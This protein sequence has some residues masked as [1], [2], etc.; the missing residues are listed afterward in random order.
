M[1]TSR[2]S[3]TAELW[4]PLPCLSSKAVTIS[5]WWVIRRWPPYPKHYMLAAASSGA[6]AVMLLLVNLGLCYLTYS[7]AKWLLQ[8]LR[9]AVDSVQTLL[10]PHP[11]P[12]QGTGDPRMEKR[13]PRTCPFP[14]LPGSHAQVTGLGH[15]KSGLFLLL[16]V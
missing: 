9:P 5:P 12:S 16:S 14:G 4:W 3:L 1:V 13:T 2:C 6:A 11:P 15:V 7:R 10:S 8:C